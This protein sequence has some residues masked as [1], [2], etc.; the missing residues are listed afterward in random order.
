MSGLA[1]DGLPNE[2]LMNIPDLSL[3]HLRIAI[4]NNR[5]S[6]P[7][8]V[9]I[10]SA[11]PRSDVQWRLAELY[12]IHNWSSAKLGPRYGLS[13]AYVNKL[14]SRWVRRATVL[15]YLQE[16]PGMEAAIDVR[17]RGRAAP[18]ANGIRAVRMQRIF[19]GGTSIDLKERIFRAAESDIYL[20]ASEWAVLEALASQVNRMVPRYELVKLLPTRRMQ[21]G[22][23]Y[24]RHVI[25][26]LRQKLEPD[27]VCPR[28]LVTERRVGYCL[29]LA[30]DP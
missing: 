17:V 20:T 16:T 2:L 30:R 10:F 29:Q 22:L 28:Y 18:C 19:L 6:F 27:P 4:R 24:L 1:S 13:G 21:R 12:F 3:D 26:D 15:G 14:I 25:R 23:D 8:Q 9:P 5:V 7:S 11:E